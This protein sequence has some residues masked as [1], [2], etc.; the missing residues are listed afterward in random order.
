MAKSRNTKVSL[1][2]LLGVC[3]L[4]ALV[5]TIL[6]LWNSGR[7]FY[8]IKRLDRDDLS[9]DATH[10]STVALVDRLH[11][12]YYVEFNDLMLQRVGEAIDIE[13]K[14]SGNIDKRE[15]SIEA[16][17][18]AWNILR[19]VLDSVGEGSGEEI[20]Y[21]LKDEKVVIFRRQEFESLSYCAFYDAS[22]LMSQTW[23]AKFLFL[24]KL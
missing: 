23:E 7:E 22:D 12:G 2:V 4:V 1:I 18:P 19:M 8:R 24:K 21:S 20:R 14:I 6:V 17:G 9:M 16:H 13:F 11:R 3:A 5:L 10:P 15:V